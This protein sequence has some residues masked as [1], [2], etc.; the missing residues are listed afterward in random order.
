MQNDNGHQD[1]FS[2]GDEE[3]F[4]EG[5]GEGGIVMMAEYETFL[6]KKEVL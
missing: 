1:I 6:V 5:K 4:L 3:V 2:G